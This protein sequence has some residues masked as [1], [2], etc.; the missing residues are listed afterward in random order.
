MDIGRDSNDFTKSFQTHLGADRAILGMARTIDSPFTAS[1][2]EI[3]PDTNVCRLGDVPPAEVANPNA[4]LTQYEETDESTY[5]WMRVRGTYLGG[6]WVADQIE[7]KRSALPRD[8]SKIT[9]NQRYV[10]IVDLQT[11]NELYIS[12]DRFK[13]LFGQVIFPEESLEKE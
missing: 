2:V 8:V 5:N 3:A 1:G 11:E 6:D 4:E 9:K 12:E 7:K 10:V 13:Q